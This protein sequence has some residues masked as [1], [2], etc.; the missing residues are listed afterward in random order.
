MFTWDKLLSDKT[1][2]GRTNKGQN[3]SRT[4][5]QD[6]YSR[7]I[8]STPFRRLQDKAQVF[9]LEENDFV[10][11]RLTHSLEVAAISKSIGISIQAKLIAQKKLEESKRGMI[12]DVL[13]CAGLAH[14]L[15]NPPFGHFGEVTLQKKF[16][17]LFSTEND[18]SEVEKKD[19]T[20]FDGN[21]QTIRILT[22]LQCI[23][24]LYGY[25]MTYATLATLMK[26]PMNSKEGNVKDGNVWHKK[27][28][29]FQSEKNIA[30]NILKE[31]GLY[32]EDGKAYRHPLAF[33]LEAADDI[34]YSAADIEDGFKKKAITF[35]D[36]KDVFTLKQTELKS[37]VIELE[38]ERIIEI[39]NVL[40]DISRLEKEKLYLSDEKRIQMLRILLQGKMISSVVVL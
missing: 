21:C 6:D 40:E 14:D 13:E 9:P 28:G 32:I 22:R 36:I 17:D 38:K 35:K 24:D 29:Y 23:K 33:I 30:E 25:H 18:L 26:Y 10:R 20:K 27:F 11:T 4:P 3:D 37:N 39:D 16:D 2:K 7:I 15:G 8:F 1:E 12:P 34:A 19:F 5:F 31:T